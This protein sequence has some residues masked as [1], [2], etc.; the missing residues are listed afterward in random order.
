MMQLAENDRETG[1]R[2][3]CKVKSI[4]EKQF[5]LPQLRRFSSTMSMLQKR[6][7]YTDM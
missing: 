1:V 6:F 7:M 3:Q 5:R 2:M 4:N